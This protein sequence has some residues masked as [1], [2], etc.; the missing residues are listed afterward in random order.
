MR[1]DVVFGDEQIQPSKRF[2]I[3]AI[4]FLLTGLVSTSSN[5]AFL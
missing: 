1:R 3:S 5:P 2:K 4:A